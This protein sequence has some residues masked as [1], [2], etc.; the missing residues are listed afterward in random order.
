MSADPGKKRRVPALPRLRTPDKEH[1]L[2]NG[3][4]HEWHP[5]TRAWWRD[6]W[7]SP[8]ASEFVQADTHGLYRLA[9]LIDKFWNNPDYTLSAEIRL[10]QQCFGLTPID[11]R[12]L[13][14]SV[15]KAE[16]A[17][18]KTQRRVMAETAPIDDPRTVLHVVNA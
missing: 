15:E 13:Q 17:T 16:E 5:L 7:R 9:M 11:R 8:M 14:W 18:C 12:R 4:A 3:K 6:V 2:E 1:P 10:E